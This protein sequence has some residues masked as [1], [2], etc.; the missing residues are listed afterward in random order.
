MADDNDDFLREIDELL[1]EDGDTNLSEEI[2]SGGT[3]G[4]DDLD[5]KLD[6]PEPVEN[7]TPK[8]RPTSDPSPPRSPSPPKTKYVLYC[9][10]SIKQLTYSTGFNISITLML[11]YL[12]G[13]CVE[14]CSVST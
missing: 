14:S 5:V 1:G 12:Q 9:L 10:S 2:D 6:D 4:L 11:L 8:P 3:F 7:S 13:R